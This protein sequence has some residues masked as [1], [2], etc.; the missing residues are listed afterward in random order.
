MLLSAQ[1]LA[2]IAVGVFNFDLLKEQSLKCLL[3][4]NL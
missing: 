1:F 2:V 4:K 3:K